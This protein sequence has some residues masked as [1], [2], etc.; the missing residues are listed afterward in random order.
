MKKAFFIAAT[1][2]G[3]LFMGKPAQAG[4]G[5]VYGSVAV[6]SY[7]YTIMISTTQ[8]DGMYAWNICNESNTGTIRCG[9]DINVSTIAGNTS[10]GFPIKKGECEYRAISSIPYCKSE[11][12][13]QTTPATR[14]VYK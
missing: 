8:A 13:G 3:L 5:A 4:I 7:T 9:Y 2:A 14:E 6:S 1:V 12:D 11:V 10:L